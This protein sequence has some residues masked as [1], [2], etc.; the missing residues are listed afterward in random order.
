MPLSVGD[1]FGQYEILSLLGKGGMEE[2][3]RRRNQVKRDV[4]IKDGRTI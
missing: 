3:Y 2:V 1:K 4:A